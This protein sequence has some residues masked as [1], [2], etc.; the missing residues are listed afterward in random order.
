MPARSAS[1]T[2]TLV[3]AMFSRERRSAGGPEVRR[4][5]TGSECDIRGIHYLLGLHEGGQ[6]VAEKVNQTSHIVLVSGKDL[7]KLMIEYDIG[8]VTRKV[9][10]IKGVDI[11]YFNAE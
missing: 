7:V 1:S 5:V 11:D 3:P 9:I 8:V 10:E 2:P 4:C 6:T